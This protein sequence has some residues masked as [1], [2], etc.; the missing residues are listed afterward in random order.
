[1]VFEPSVRWQWPLAQPFTHSIV[2]EKT[3]SLITTL[4]DYNFYGNICTG[5]IW[6]LLPDFPS[7]TDILPPQNP[8]SI[9]LDFLLI[10]IRYV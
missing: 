4:N 10:I 1:M 5:K 8:S 9:P 6:G 7:P 3:K 2:I